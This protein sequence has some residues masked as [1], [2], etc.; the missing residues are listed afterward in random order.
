MLLMSEGNENDQ[1]LDKCRLSIT[2]RNNKAPLQGLRKEHPNLCSSSMGFC[3]KL[4]LINTQIGGEI[5]PEAYAG[6]G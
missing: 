3:Y 1:S 4:T 5:L 2:S 6:I